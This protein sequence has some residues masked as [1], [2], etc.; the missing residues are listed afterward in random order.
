MLHMGETW[1]RAI[2]LK[3]DIKQ[4]RKDLEEALH[5]IKTP[6]ADIQQQVQRQI[7]TPACN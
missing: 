2:N 5:N 3:L 1:S 4:R 7:W 6:E